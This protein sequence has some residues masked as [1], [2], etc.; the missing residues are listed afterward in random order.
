MHHSRPPEPGTGAQE[1]PLQPDVG[2]VRQP[3]RGVRQP[4]RVCGS[5][6]DLG[7]A[8]RREE[9]LA[10]RLGFAGRD[11]S[12]ARVGTAPRSRPVRPEM[13]LGSAS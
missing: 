6:I 1:R 9:D 2:I 4:L 10:K 12:V 13:Y 3:D 5:R 8:A 11:M 7:L